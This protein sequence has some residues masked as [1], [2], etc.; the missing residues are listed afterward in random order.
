[1]NVFLSFITFFLEVYAFH[2][3]ESAKIYSNEITNAAAGDFNYDGKLDLMVVGGTDDT[4][5]RIF[6]GE[7][8]KFNGGIC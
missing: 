2:A 8:D 7:L 6:F 1:M 4:Y 5:V 3:L